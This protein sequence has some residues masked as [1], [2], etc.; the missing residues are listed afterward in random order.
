[1]D[2]GVVR[3][4]SNNLVHSSQ[5]PGGKLR[6]NVTRGTIKS[7]YRPV[8]L[9]KKNTLLGWMHL[10]PDRGK[11][12]WPILVPST[13]EMILSLLSCESNGLLLHEFT[14][15]WFY[16]LVSKG[17]NGRDILE[18]FGN[19]PITHQGIGTSHLAPPYLVS[20]VYKWVGHNHPLVWVAHGY[21]ISHQGCWHCLQMSK[22][23]VRTSP[24]RAGSKPANQNSQLTWDAQIG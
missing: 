5:L 7:F 23:L 13:W 15:L 12:P 14:S 17:T 8:D 2:A 1:M 21:S 9:S 6:K 22:P 19:N 16:E 4:L 10:C 11:T 18:A 20:L 24:Q 3:D